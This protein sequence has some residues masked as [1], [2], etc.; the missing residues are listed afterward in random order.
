MS[1]AAATA[2]SCWRAIEGKYGLNCAICDFTFVL[3]RSSPLPGPPVVNPDGGANASPHGMLPAA[4]QEEDEMQK[5]S[6]YCLAALATIGFAGTASAQTYS[7][8][9][10]TIALT[11]TTLTVHKGL[12][13]NCTLTNSNLS[14]ASTPAQV[15]SL[16]LA[17][18][19]CP[20]VTFTGTPYNVST[21]D[22]S[23]IVIQDVRV[24]GITGNCRGDL[25]GSFSSGHIIFSN[26]SIPSDPPGGSPCTISGTVDT[27]PSVSYTI[28]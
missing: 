11:T 22:T 21:P 15:T 26:A 10:S 27:N 2:G 3:V 20:S 24:V 4:E 12:T 18:G 13:L 8:V 7:P 23:H 9:S 6:A 19:L 1:K 25:A 28:P 16:R 14:T 5:I 17:G